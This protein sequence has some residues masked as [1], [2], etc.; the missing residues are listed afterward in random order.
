MYNELYEIWKREQESDEVERLPS[1]FYSKIVDYLRKLKE[2]SRML[3]KR[4]IKA[5]L[6]KKEMHN[7]KHMIHDLIRTRYRKIM[8]KTVKGEKVQ[9]DVLAVEEEKIYAGV[10][11]FAEAYRDFA[12]SVLSGYA[13]KINIEKERK[14]TVLRFLKVVPAV[15]GADMKPYGPFN[16]EDVASLPIE[17]AKILIK[18]GLAEKVEG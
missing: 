12:K 2:E 4:T 8:R 18:E 15:I 10:L 3:D 16:V 9:S 13:P 5:R 11:P 6:L 14:K 1:D 7:I 17:N